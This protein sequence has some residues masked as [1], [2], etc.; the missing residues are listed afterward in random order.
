MVSM[1]GS[2]GRRNRLLNSRG[3]RSMAANATTQTCNP[4]KKDFTLVFN[5]AIPRRTWRSRS[6]GRGSRV[7]RVV[8]CPDRRGLGTRMKREGPGIVSCPDRSSCDMPGRPGAHGRPTAGARPGT[9]LGRE[10]I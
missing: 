4:V 6:R 2:T 3:S 7:E 5:I 8:S 9:R 1:V 10:V